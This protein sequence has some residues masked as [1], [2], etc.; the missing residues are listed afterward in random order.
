MF[1]ASEPKEFFC[2]EIDILL[3]SI[4]RMLSTISSILVFHHNKDIEILFSLFSILFKQLW[5]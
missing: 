5:P 1:Y 2:P 3:F 4:W